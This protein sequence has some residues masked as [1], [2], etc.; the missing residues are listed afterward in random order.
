M[1]RSPRDA[2][3]KCRRSPLALN[4]ISQPN[5]RHLR[6][7]A[8]APH[9]PPSTSLPAKP[10]KRHHLHAARALPG[11]AALEQHRMHELPRQVPTCARRMSCFTARRA[12][13]PPPQP[14]GTEP[15]P[16]A[17]THSQAC[18]PK[19][20]CR[21]K[22]QMLTARVIPVSERGA[23]RP[24]ARDEHDRMSFQVPVLEE[25][26]LVQ[27]AVHPCPRARALTY[28]QRQPVVNALN[29]VKC[30]PSPLQARHDEFVIDTLGINLSA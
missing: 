22:P 18:T 8:T 6:P 23:L 11:K 16:D 5:A 30:V 10:P 28:L 20:Y 13:A 29:T 7:I 15:I 26:A 19:R 14:A 4:S 24:S 25:Y 27:L 2:L 1:L 9:R 21:T 17:R 3:A 12:V